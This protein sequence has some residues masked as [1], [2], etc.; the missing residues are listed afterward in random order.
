MQCNQA[1]EKRLE[2]GFTLGVVFY[3]ELQSDNIFILGNFFIFSMT[4]MSI[5]DDDEA[6]NRMNRV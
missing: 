2:C 5:V 1:L 3:F 4:N 6:N